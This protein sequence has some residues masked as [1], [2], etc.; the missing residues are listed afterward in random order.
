[1]RNPIRSDNLGK[2]ILRLTVGILILF[3]GVFKLLHPESLESI[4]K[5]LAAINLPQPVAYGVLVGEVI[6]PIMVIV[7]F[8]S[9]IG[10]LLISGNMIFA[11]LLAH[12]A[13]LFTLTANG[14]WALE[15]QGF[16]L[17]SGLAVLFLGSGRLALKPD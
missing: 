12:R 16:Y 10:A 2:L 11:L 3:H 8:Y 15:L 1:M 7:G 13:Q 9:R 5:M 14:G 6:A 4:S 17:F